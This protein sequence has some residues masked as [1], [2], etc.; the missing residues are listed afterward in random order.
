LSDEK[1][2]MYYSTYIY[3]YDNDS[4]QATFNLRRTMNTLHWHLFASDSECVKNYA[5]RLSGYPEKLKEW[6]AYKKIPYEHEELEYDLTAYSSVLM[7]RVDKLEKEEVE[8]LN[9]LLSQAHAALE[10]VKRDKTIFS[11]FQ[12][13]MNYLKSYDLGVK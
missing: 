9:P 10:K 13:A 6:N 3:K 11:N 2:V 5:E 12:Y 7:G 4:Y 1:Y 8:K